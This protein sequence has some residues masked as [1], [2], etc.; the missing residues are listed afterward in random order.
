VRSTQSA[1]DRRVRTIVLTKEGRQ[2]VARAKRR[3]WPMIEAA[4]ADACAAPPA[5]SLLSALAAVEEALAVAELSSRA[6][7]LGAV[8]GRRAPA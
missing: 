2:L 4:V 3:A 5:Q 7:R 6:K 1:E 8:E